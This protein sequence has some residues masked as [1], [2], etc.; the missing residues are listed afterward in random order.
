VGSGT[1]G[2]PF[3]VST[4][5]SEG[6]QKDQKGEAPLNK[7]KG[8]SGGKRKT[9]KGEAENFRCH[10]GDQHRTEN[11]PKETL[12]LLRFP[13][14]PD[15]EPRPAQSEK[16]GREEKNG[17]ILFP[18]EPKKA[19]LDHLQGCHKAQDGPRPIAGPKPKYPA[20][21]FVSCFGFFCPEI[22]LRTIMKK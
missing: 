10:P 6:T 4:P 3:R 16:A 22:Y 7:P 20:I 18:G 11:H 8:E 9:R 17:K 15:Q 14:T 21:H 1:L 19:G 12:S 2:P 13:A 5:G